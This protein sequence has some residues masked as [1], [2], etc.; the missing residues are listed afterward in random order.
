[1]TLLYDRALRVLLGGEYRLREDIQING[2][3]DVKFTTPLL[4]GDF[5][6][7]V[8]KYINPSGTIV[9]SGWTITNKIP[10]GFTFTP[11]TRYQEGTLTYEAR[12]YK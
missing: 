2:V 5:E 6:V 12:Y 1:M 4:V 7:T 11:P 10:E 3:T 8:L 9:S